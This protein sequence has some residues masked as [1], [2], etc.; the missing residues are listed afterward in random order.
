MSNE[1]K[2]ILLKRMIWVWQQKK[3]TKLRE[4]N[5]TSVELLFSAS[6]CEWGHGKVC[7]RKHFWYQ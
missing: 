2:K 7:N 6:L 5:C 1:Y 3:E 4:L